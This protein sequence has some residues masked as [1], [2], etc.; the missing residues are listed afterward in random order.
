[1]FPLGDPPAGKARYHRTVEVTGSS[2]HF[3]VSFRGRDIPLMLGKQ[4]VGRTL[5]NKIHLVDQ[6]VSRR[7]A[8][9]NVEERRVILEDLGSANGVYVDGARIAEAQVLTDGS[10][11]VIGKQEL[12]FRG[13]KPA[14]RSDTATT[15]SRMGRATIDDLHQPQSDAGTERGDALRLLGL[16]AE[17][18][19][20]KG[21][22]GRAETILS[23][24]LKNHLRQM[25]EGVASPPEST[26]LVGKYALA[27]AK[28]TK[29]VTWIDFLFEVYG[30]SS[31]V[32]SADTVEDLH[33]LLRELPPI[34]L[35]LLRHYIE[36]LESKSDKL[37]P[38]ELFI[39]QRLEGLARV[40]AAQ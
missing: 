3:R 32:M 21:D 24:H 7:H 19:L 34:K 17:R 35:K 12:V 10:H 9:F 8:C 37:L 23:V 2:E 13:S 31:Q 25:R 15:D 36:Q 6:L 30:L 5:D 39:V 22:I 11:I 40:A 33:S 27:L 26:S 16:I 18:L 14:R 20:E 4:T 28:A 38:A 1:M 29:R